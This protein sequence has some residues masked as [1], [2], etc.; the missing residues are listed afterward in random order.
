MWSDFPTKPYND[1]LVIISSIA[2]FEGA[3]TIILET[4]ELNNI[5][6]IPVIVYVYPVPGGP[7]ISKMSLS[8]ISI[9]LSKTIS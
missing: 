3:H 7:Y 4:P 9:T 6:I 8:G 1:I 2:A 5:D